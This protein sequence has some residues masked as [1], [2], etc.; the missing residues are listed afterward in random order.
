M[1]TAPP[2]PVPTT[3][4]ATRAAHI[5]YTQAAQAGDGEVLVSRCRKAGTT[6]RRCV[7]TITGRVPQRFVFKVRGR[8]NDTVWCSSWPLRTGAVR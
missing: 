2:V 1:I 4:E 5:I 3:A 6:T 7:V 8:R